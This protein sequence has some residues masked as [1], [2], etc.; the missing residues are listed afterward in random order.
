VQARCPDCAGEVLPK[1]R[2]CGAC[3]RPLGEETVRVAAELA[4]ASA[5]ARLAATLLDGL[6]LLIV[7][8]VWLSLGWP[9]GPLGVGLLALG[10]W[11]LLPVGAG[12]TLGQ[13]VMGQVVLD[14]DRRPLS[15]R[16]SL[17]RTLAA[18]ASWPALLPLRALLRADGATAAD[19]WTGTRT[20]AERRR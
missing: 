14:A 18:A 11:S 20:W 10:W 1:E 15:W 3:G 5:P 8:E 7:Y 2:F 16:A 19:A 9:A 4:P 12:Q 6:A 13:H 17:R